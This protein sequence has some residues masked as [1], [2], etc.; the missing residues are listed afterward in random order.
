MKLKLT[1]AL[2]LAAGLALPAFADDV[3]IPNDTGEPVLPLVD[4]PTDGY[5]YKCDLI[6]Q[7]LDTDVLYQFG[8]L[9]YIEGDGVIVD[10]ILEIEL[11]QTWVGDLVAWLWY[12]FDCDGPPYDVGP[13]YALCRAQLDGCPFPDDCCGCSGDVIGEF[14]FS[15]AGSMPLGE[16]DCPTLIPPGCYTPAIESPNPFAVFN[17]EPT[18][19]CFYLELGDAAAGDDTYLVEWCIWTKAEPPVPVESTTWGKIK[20]IYE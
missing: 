6:T 16:F 8:P 7:L 3:K 17:G 19:G 12:D 18:G 15:D 13:V 1:L 5:D 11:E 14:F 10:A 4:C 20:A 2:L 9:G